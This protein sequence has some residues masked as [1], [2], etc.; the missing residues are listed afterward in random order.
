MCS[1]LEMLWSWLN[2][3]RLLVHNVLRLS[4]VL[5]CTMPNMWMMNSDMSMYCF[6]MQVRNR[7]K[8]RCKMWRMRTSETSPPISDSSPLAPFPKSTHK[9]GHKA[10]PQEWHATAWCLCCCF[11]L[12]FLFYF[13]FCPLVLFLMFFFIIIIIIPLIETRNH[14]WNRH[15]L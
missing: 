14:F 2:T 5:D 3:L 13:Y 11:F 15:Q 9:S 1:P 12:L 10:Q 8:R 4:G 7:I 6:N